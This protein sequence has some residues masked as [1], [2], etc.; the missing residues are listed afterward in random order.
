MPLFHLD[1]RIFSL[2]TEFWVGRVFFFQN[3][4]DVVPG[5]DPRWQHRETSHRHTESTPTYRAIPHEEELMLIELH[6]KGYRNHIE[7][8]W[9]DRD[10]VTTETLS[11]M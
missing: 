5:G 3:F 2:D 6:S 8:S 1:S 7:K 11:L 4:K 9:R 10:M